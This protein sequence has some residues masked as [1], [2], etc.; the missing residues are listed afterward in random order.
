M[1]GGTKE[2]GLARQHAVGILDGFF[3][4]LADDQGVGAIVDHLPF[5]LGTL[6]V[7]VFNLLA[8]QDQL[9]LIFQRNGAFADALHLEFGLNLHD[10][11]IAEVGRHVV[12]GLFIGVGKRGN[13]VFAVKELEGVVVDD[14]GRVA[15][16]PR[17]MVLK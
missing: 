3:H 10:L 14:V 9:F 6:E 12:H 1:L 16:R 15:V 8:L 2:D 4:E 13:A 5:K 17:V 7:D 11:K